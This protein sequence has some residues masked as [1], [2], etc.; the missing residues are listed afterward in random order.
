MSAGRFVAVKQTLIYLVDNAK[1]EAQKQ[2]EFRS[3]IG[4]MT[5]LMS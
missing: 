5:W 3:T 4:S 1:D 2:G